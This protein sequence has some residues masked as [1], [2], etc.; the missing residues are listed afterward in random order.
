MKTIKNTK[1]ASFEVNSEAR[2]SH[3]K[4]TQVKPTRVPTYP[5]DGVPLWIRH[6]LPSFIVNPLRKHIA[7]DKTLFDDM[8]SGM[9]QGDEP[10]DRVI[11]WM[12]KV[13]PRQGKIQFD[14]ALEKGIDSIDDPDGPI[15]DFF[16]MIDNSPAWVDMAE[17]D[18]GAMTCNIVGG[19]A[20][21]Y[22]RD[23]ALMGGYVFSGLNPPL[24]LTGALKNSASKRFA[25][26]F[27]Y[28]V[29]TW[30]VGGMTRFGVGFKSAIRIRMI[31]ALVRRNLQLKSEWN[32]EKWGI[33]ISQTDMLSSYLGPATFS[34]GARVQ[35]VPVT[36]R[37]EKA[38]IHHAAFAGWL[39]GVKEEWLVHDMHGVQKMMIHSLATQ[40][41]GDD[42]SKV[43]ARSLVAE[44]M[45]R[46]FKY[47]Q[48]LQRKWH[49]HKHLSVSSFYLPKT[50]IKD[51]GI[52]TTIPWV[53]MVT[54]PSR[55][56]WHAAHRLLP[57]GKKRLAEKGFE[58]Q[59]LQ[60]KIFA[61]YSK[62]ATAI[63]DTYANHPAHIA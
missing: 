37:E 22:M 14:Q 43:M 11:D 12:F 30:T 47:F 16:A 36:K 9:W 60:S 45:S 33:P 41:L 17:V 29:D 18:F 50:V 27:S 63:V 15:M 1:N 6:I 26:T 58:K 38:V 40:P 44:P 57:G 54:I 42:N 61:K 7:M 20:P 25:E 35:G 3:Y 49:H 34:V 46:E 55:F 2:I 53:P 51:L 24:V 48:Q 59:K 19:A 28:G 31:H 32:F 8:V 5:D 21:S 10:M 23:I 56:V 4:E 52:E 13:G 62:S 39:L